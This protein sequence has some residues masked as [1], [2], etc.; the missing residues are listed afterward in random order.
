MY[1][2]SKMNALVHMI[3]PNCCA[4]C[5]IR[6]NKTICLNCSHKIMEQAKVKKCIVCACLSNELLCKYCL[7]SKPKFD[8]TITLCYETSFLVPIIR[9]SVLFRSIGY[10]ATLI[11]AWTIALFRE[12]PP[13]DILIPLPELRKNSQSRGYW[14]SLE[15]IKQMSRLCNTPYNA[16]IVSYNPMKL[17]SIKNSS[18]FVI[19]PE[20]T[21]KGLLVNK[22]IAIFMPYL[23]NETTLNN[24]AMQLKAQGALWVSFWVLTR[25][26][27]KESY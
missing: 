2:F 25:N 16:N 26:S 17:S 9:R 14:F 13:I 8:Q 12:V 19:N 24:L 3:L 10:L 1:F 23:L 11:E 20:C 27:F 4:I 21:S 15:F 22:R 7:F 5:H 18:V 6:Q